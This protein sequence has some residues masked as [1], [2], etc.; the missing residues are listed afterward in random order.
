MFSDYIT[1]YRIQIEGYL[2]NCDIP[3]ETSLKKAKNLQPLSLQEIIPLITTLDPEKRKMILDVSRIITRNIHGEKIGLIAPLYINNNC[4][5]A[6]RYCGMSRE[7]KNIERK[8][9]ESYDQFAN[10]VNWLKRFNYDTIEMVAGGCELNLQE[11]NIYFDILDRLVQNVAFFFDTQTPEIYKIMLNKRE[12]LTMMHWQETYVKED[13]QLYHPKNTKKGD[14]NNRL[15]AI[16]YAINGGLKK[17]LIGVLF[18]LADPVLDVLLCISHGQYLT[19]TYDIQPKGIGIVRIQPT[20]GA[21]IVG[22]PFNVSEDSHL[23]YSAILRIAFPKAEM[24]ATSRESEAHISNLLNYSATF[25]NVTCTTVPG[26]Y[27]DITRAGI[28]KNGQFFHNSPTY[29]AVKSMVEKINL[30]LDPKKPL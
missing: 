7:N 21:E 5:N 29:N 24:I 22:M 27:N 18:G 20:S 16:E 19:S 9:I 15:N 26:G 25:T 23:F 17:Y 8:K 4:D 13:Y 1:Q 3:F 11:I 10:E 30:K 14:F 12:H 2:K 6:C 28:Q